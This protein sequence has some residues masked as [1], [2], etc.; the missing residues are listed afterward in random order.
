VKEG[1]QGFTLVELL[2]VIVIIGVL[3]TLAIPAFLNQRQKGWDAAVVSD[4]RNAAVAEETWLTGNPAYT[5]SVAD[6]KSVGFKYS[7]AES[8]SSSP[9]TMAIIVTGAQSYCLKATSRSG[10]TFYFDNAL[11][12]AAAF[13]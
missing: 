8:Y 4:L 3:A 10:R 5:A 6:L 13:C 9:A 7:G 12:G 2:V 11:G 1:D